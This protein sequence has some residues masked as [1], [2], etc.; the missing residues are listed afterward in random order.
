MSL[1]KKKE[2]PGSPFH[3]KY[4]IVSKPESIV[5]RE[6]PD[7]GY[8]QDPITFVVD[9]SD[10]G[11]GELVVKVTS[12]ATKEKKPELIIT[13]NKDRTYSIGYTPN[14]PGDHKFDILWSG[15]SIPGSPFG[16]DVLQ[17]VSEEVPVIEE[18]ATV[19]PDALEEAS[20]IPQYLL[21]E[22]ETEE[23]AQ[24]IGLDVGKGDV[25]ERKPEEYT[26]MLGRATKT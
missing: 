8:V 16:V 6:L 17:P 10:A 18:S 24:E 20:F 11:S 22:L 12:P 3:L 23:P 1:I 26:I 19:I 7:I 2:V 14:A 9:T 15:E 21:D 13:D 25:K 4:D 5:V